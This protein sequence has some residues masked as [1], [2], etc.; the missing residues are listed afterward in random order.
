MLTQEVFFFF[1]SDIMPMDNQSGPLSMFCCGQST[2]LCKDTVKE[3][4]TVFDP[5]T[6]RF[7]SNL[8]IE[9]MFSYPFSSWHI[10]A[11]GA[12]RSCP[13]FWEF[14]IT[15]SRQPHYNDG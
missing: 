14:A 8:D 15:I 10:S 13:G 2:K 9:H 4:D 12:L 6:Q 1:L 3:V 7:G 5:N 11:G